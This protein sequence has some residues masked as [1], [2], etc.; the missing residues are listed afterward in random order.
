MD[1]VTEILLNGRKPRL[2]EHL[3]DRLEVALRS[4]QR[5]RDGRIGEVAPTQ[6]AHQRH[7]D[8]GD[9]SDSMTRIEPPLPSRETKARFSWCRNASASALPTG[10]RDSGVDVPSFDRL[11]RSARLQLTRRS[12][13]RTHACAAD[14]R[15][16][17][18]G[19]DVAPRRVHT[20][21]L[22]LPRETSRRR[23]AA[24]RDPG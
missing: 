4:V 16:Q 12:S 22:V 11:D 24:T 10:E 2:V 19:V 14:R 21:A 18:R 9:V 5:S 1:P 23:H 13:R 20:R 7:I 17:A 15:Q 8:R 3:E 6:A